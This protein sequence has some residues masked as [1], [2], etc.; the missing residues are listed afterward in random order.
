MEKNTRQFEELVKVTCEET[1]AISEEIISHAENY[2]KTS[3]NSN[4]HLSL[5][6]HLAFSMEEYRKGN[7]IENDIIEEIRILYSKEFQVGLWALRNLRDNTGVE[8]PE[9]E[10]GHIALYLKTAALGDSDVN[11][12]LRQTRIVRD[13]AVF[14]NRNFMNTIDTNSISYNRLLANLSKSLSIAATGRNGREMDKDMLALI[15]KKYRNAYQ[16]ALNVSGY[17]EK[18]YDIHYPENEISYLTLH[19][20]RAVGEHW[21]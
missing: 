3:L 1:I 2:L 18:E 8:L 4:V 17:L 5:A 19:I 10:A 6:D 7:K 20:S 13:L 15:Q 9:E 12:A 16:C 21:S 14:I 11:V